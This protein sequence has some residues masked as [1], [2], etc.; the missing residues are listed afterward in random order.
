VEAM[1]LSPV[2]SPPRFALRRVV[3]PTFRVEFEYDGE[4]YDGGE[5]GLVPERRVAKRTFFSESPR[6]AGSRDG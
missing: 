6:I 1:T 2:G 3:R 4:T 5:D